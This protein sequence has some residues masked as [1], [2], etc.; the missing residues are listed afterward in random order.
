MKS[1]DELENFFNKFFYRN[2]NKQR[3]LKRIFQWRRYLEWNDLT[4]EEKLT[5]KRFLLLPVFAY[6]ILG[7]FSQYF[8]LISLF[9]IGYILYK[10]FENN[11][12][13]KK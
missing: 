2:K 13:V 10:K 4:L 3:K 11:N 7:I 5:A 8:L 9:L 1:L 6:I 12:I